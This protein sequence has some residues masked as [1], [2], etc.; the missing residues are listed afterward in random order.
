MFPLEWKRKE[1]FR[2]K[3][4]GGGEKSG[5]GGARSGILSLLVGTDGGSDSDKCSTYGSVDTV[6]LNDGGRDGDINHH[7]SR[8]TEQQISVQVGGV[9]GEHEIHF[10]LSQIPF[11]AVLNNWNSVLF[12]FLR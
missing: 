4:A 8:G 1:E 5:D 12:R 11:I 2:E 3:S 6:I 10:T 9:G 7:Y